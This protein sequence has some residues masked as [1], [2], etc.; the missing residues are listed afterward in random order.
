MHAD[1]LGDLTRTIRT[2]AVSRKQALQLIGGL[3]AVAVPARL[4]QAAEA[5]KHAKPPLAFVQ[6]TMMRVTPNDP[7]TFSWELNAAV[8]HPDFDTQLG[9]ADV[10]I[11]VPSTLTGDK[12][13]AKIV[14]E[15]KHHAA[16]SLAFTFDQD[17]PEDRIVVTL[18]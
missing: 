1:F 2:V 4:P 11:E 9:M 15:L 12:L 14:A 3:M 8:T 5:G 18:I 10:F 16:F 17:V 6:A 13:R 7:F